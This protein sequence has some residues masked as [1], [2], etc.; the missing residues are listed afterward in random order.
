MKYFLLLVTLASTFVQAEIT[1]KGKGHV[2]N[3]PIEMQLTINDKGEVEGNYFYTKTKIPISLS[4]EFT[5]NRVKLNTIGN[6]KIQERFEGKAILFNNE[7]ARF[8]GQWYGKHNTDGEKTK[9]YEF[10][11]EGSANPLNDKV[12]TCEEMAQ[13][14]ELVFELGDLGSGHGSPNRVDYNCPK[15]LNQLSFLQKLIGSASDIRSPS[16]LPQICT[17]SIVHA[18]WRYYHF[19]LAK[20]G[21]Y[22]Q[23]Y[24]NN[25]SKNRGKEYFEEWSYHSLHNREIYHD[26]MSELGRVRPLLTDWYI[27]NHKI[28]KEKANQFTEAALTHISNYGF[29]SYE[30]TWKPEAL[31]PHTSD[32][33]NGDY[34]DFLASIDLATDI[35]KLNS[36]RRLVMHNTSFEIVEKLLQSI[37]N[38]GI[39]GRSETP[40][41]NAV[42][43]A[44]LVALLLKAGFNP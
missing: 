28:G 36:L 39:S 18:Q 27:E 43:N 25:R 20:L 21:Y 13:V 24:S 16:H 11:V 14:P 33:I 17:G 44:E 34:G 9:G 7:I 37:E 35:Q 1:L 22:P 42:K 10:K 31:V 29:G 41:S 32:V 40:V 30:Y 2:A 4:G 5:S 15:S 38:K 19:D 26:Y 23:G 6:P 12:V 3:V 8:S